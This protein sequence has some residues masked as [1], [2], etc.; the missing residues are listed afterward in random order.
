LVGAASVRFWPLFDVRK[1]NPDRSLHWP[2]PNLVIDP[3]PDTGP[4]LVTNVYTVPPERE[5]RFF[6]AMRAVRLSRLRTGAI[7]WGLYRDGETA[8]RF[9]ETYTVLSWDEHLRQ[10]HDRLTGT[11][12]AI[13]REARAL[14]D[15][16]VDVSHL[17]PVDLTD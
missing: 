3:E 10:H 11:D 13:E 4:V 6:E 17:F 9:V 5:Q 7:W 14:A 12:L 16:S 15:S 2:E 1:F 8:N